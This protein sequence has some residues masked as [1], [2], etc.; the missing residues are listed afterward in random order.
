MLVRLLS[1]AF[2]TKMAVKESYLGYLN[3]LGIPWNL[4]FLWSPFV[5][6]F[7]TKRRWLTLMQLAIAALTMGV[8]VLCAMCPDPKDSAAE[9]FLLAI[10]VIFVGSAFLA[11]TNDVA[12]D[13][14]YLEVLTDKKEQAA[15]TGH[16]V[17]AYRVAM[18]FA[19]SGLVA[20]AA[21]AGKLAGGDDQPLAWAACFGAGALTMFALAIFHGAKLPHV[22]AVS[23]DRRSALEVLETY[24]RAF[25][26]YIQQ[27]RFLLVVLFVTVY[28]LGDDVLFAMTTPFLMRELKV[29]TGQ[30]AWIAG[31]VG[32]IGASGGALIGSWWIKRRGFRRAIWPMT[33]LMNVNIWAYVWLSWL[34]PDAS[35]TGGELTIALVHGYEQLAAG[36]GNAALV[37]YLLRTCK[38]EFKAAHYAFGSALISIG[39][40]VLGG[41]AGQFVERY[42]YFD[43]FVG[44]FVLTLPSMILLF[45]VPLADV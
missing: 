21:L 20:L 18:I 22:E 17:T 7:S 30:F 40:S 32:A 11:A 44:S 2:F 36:L 39:S 43:L 37:V 6:A 12:I 4:K 3:F 1:S 42:G 14:Y 38:P 35:T 10:A 9:P 25:A 33:L 34:K 28:K 23:R 27:E 45:F 15:F 31:I 8:A 41:F 26:S 5:D 16:R 29:T 13:G 19:R 24:G